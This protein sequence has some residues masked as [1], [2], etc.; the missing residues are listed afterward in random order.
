MI[1]IPSGGHSPQWWQ[2]PS[3]HLAF[4]L[5]IP[6]PQFSWFCSQ[7]QKD[8][9][10]LCP[11]LQVLSFISP[12]L[13]SEPCLYFQSLIK[14][15]CYCRIEWLSALLL[16]SDYIFTLSSKLKAIHYRYVRYGNSFKILFSTHL[17]DFCWFSEHC[18]YWSGV[19]QHFGLRNTLGMRTLTQ[20]NL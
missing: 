16:I 3:R 7:R 5:H 17:Q 15:S 9:L 14:R 13:Y 4:A 2:N 20:S 11:F 18:T 6:N 10:P 19:N 12:T 1:S 8:H